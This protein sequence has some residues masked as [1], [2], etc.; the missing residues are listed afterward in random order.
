[1]TTLPPRALHPALVP[2]V[3]V[4]ET[5]RTYRTDGLVFGVALAVTIALIAWGV[6]GG[7]HLS[8][9]AAGALGWVVDYFGIFFT[10]IATIVLVFM[11]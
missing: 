10:T 3:S 6:F 9:T 8:A 2:G 1:M 4:E 11:L 7:D 5:G